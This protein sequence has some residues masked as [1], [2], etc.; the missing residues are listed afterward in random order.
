MHGWSATT[1][2]S[3]KATSRHWL[4]ARRDDVTGGFV[5]GPTAKSYSSPRSAAFTVAPAGGALNIC[6]SGAW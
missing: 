6:V 5:A 3:Y 2:S 1:S 4:P